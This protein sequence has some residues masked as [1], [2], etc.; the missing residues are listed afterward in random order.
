QNMVA[1]MNLDLATLLENLSGPSG[2][3]SLPPSPDQPGVPTLPPAPT[4]PPTSTVPVPGLPCLPGLCTEA[5][6]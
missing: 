5:G 4:L 2:S 1:T 6:G 3:P